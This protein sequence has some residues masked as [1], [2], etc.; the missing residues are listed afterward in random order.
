M[1]NPTIINAF[2]PDYMETYHPN[3][4]KEFIRNHV[5]SKNTT[6]AVTKLR[7]KKPTHGTMFGMSEKA[8]SLKPLEFLTYSRAGAPKRK[9][10]A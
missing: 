9:V 5:I 10:A 4:W 1:T 7:A 3:F 8:V 2:H 6:E